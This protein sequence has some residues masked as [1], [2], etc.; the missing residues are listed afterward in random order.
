MASLA[1]STAWAA[2]AP[3]SD[4][5]SIMAEI[6]FM[7]LASQAGEVAGDGGNFFRGQFFGHRGHQSMGIGGA[8]AALPGLELAL[9]IVGVLAGQAREYFS[10]THSFGTVAGHAT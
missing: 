7:L 9:Y 2:V 1:V 5:P 8:A 3:A 6:R 10:Y 4:R